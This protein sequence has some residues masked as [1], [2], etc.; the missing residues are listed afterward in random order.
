VVAAGNGGLE[1][2]S[3]TRTD[4]RLTDNH[5]RAR[6]MTMTEARRAFPPPGCMMGSLRP[7]WHELIFDDLN[8]GP[9]HSQVIAGPD[10]KKSTSL[11]TRAMYHHGPRV[12]L[13]PSCELGPIMSRALRRDGYRVYTIGIAQ[14]GINILDW[15]D[16]ND[17]ESNAHIRSVVEWC[18]N[19]DT[20][21]GGGIQTEHNPYWIL[22]G[23]DLVTC[24]LAHIMHGPADV[25]KTI[26]QVHRFIAVS[27]TQIDTLLTGI[28]G[29]S[30][31]SMAR[32]LAASLM[33]MQAKETFSS[34]CSNARN[35]VSY[36]ADQA[37][38]DIISG[39]ALH[40][41]DV[42]D[43]RTVIFIQIPMRTLQA[44][45]A[46]ARALIGAL[47]NAVFHADGEELSRQR[48]LM[49]LD[50]AWLLGPMR[51]I[52]TAHASGR[53]Y[54]LAVQTIWQSEGQ[55][56]ACWGRYGAQT[57][58]DTVSWRSYN[59]I[60]DGTVAKR[61]SEDMGSHGV[62]AA[63]RG[64]NFGTQKRWSP[65]A[66]GSRSAGGNSNV[67]E[68]KRA[69]MPHDEILRAPASK[70][71]ILKRNCPHPIEAWAAPYFL[72]PRLAARLGVNRF[73]TVR[74]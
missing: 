22:R 40:T 11:V 46:I 44:T 19:T 54:R 2:V 14:Q 34:I 5:G 16:I 31:S 49:M 53:K 47:F 36:L 1:V 52:L 65:F 32:D 42:L 8:Q 59:G 61:L 12:I 9:G 58:R 30:D 48:V 20:A 67:H 17:P 51:E 4:L 68:I 26:R 15:I 74:Q 73:A 29:L 55:I 37:Y 50:E 71:W 35:A 28:N 39:D 60:S 3:G 6:F 66:L 62:L 63:S 33:G 13:D 43:P 21:G 18:Y 41:S 23:K 57:L 64:A 10:S 25:V 72:D 24:I 69:L 56:E 27:E 38:A 7:D 45:P 70:M